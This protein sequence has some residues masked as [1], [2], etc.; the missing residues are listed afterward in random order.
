M[1]EQKNENVENVNNEVKAEVKT[2]R[3]ILLLS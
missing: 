3:N 2:E 1:E